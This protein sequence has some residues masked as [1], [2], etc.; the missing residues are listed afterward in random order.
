MSA[1]PCGTV[2][3]WGA[4]ASSDAVL[5]SAGCPRGGSARGTGPSAL[6]SLQTIE[7]PPLP[8]PVPI[9]ALLVC[10]RRGG[11]GVHTDCRWPARAERGCPRREYPPWGGGCHVGW[12]A[13]A[14]VGQIRCSRPRGVEG[15]RVLG[16]RGCH[17]PWA[18]VGG[19][20]WIWGVRGVL[21]VLG[22]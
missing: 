17:M 1:W 6:V 11:D 9:P 3:T 5:V 20:R 21:G 10:R 18:A 15:W 14:G 12:G 4:R 19:C 13:D 16:A 2:R 8:G 7:V 22:R